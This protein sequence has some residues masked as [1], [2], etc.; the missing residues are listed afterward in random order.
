MRDTPLEWGSLNLPL[1]GIAT[2]WHGK[3]LRP[4]VAFT[5]ATDGDK[6][7]FIATRQA[8]TAIHPGAEPGAFTA[9]LWKHDVAE[10]FIAAPEGGR[11]I[12][13][14]LAP[15]GA[16][17]A[18]EF[19]GVREAAVSQPDFGSAIASFHDEV[20]DDSWLAA[21]AIPL[22]F[23]REEIS[24]GSGSRAN[25]AFILNSPKQTFHSAAK[26]PGDVAD[27]HQPGAF[28]ALVTT[29]APAQ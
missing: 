7:W 16:W 26:L 25:V 20:E 8:A 28:P 17:W 19:D 12:E 27:F 9:E 4:P 6:L 2:D 10:L 15:N 22:G 5:L 23:L 13:F 14:N 1:L 24:F 18:C 11:Y 29:E 3:N 21:M